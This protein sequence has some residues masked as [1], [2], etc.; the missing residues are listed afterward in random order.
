MCT[1]PGRYWNKSQK[2]QINTL[3]SN[4]NFESL[5]ASMIYQLFRT[6]SLVPNPTQGWGKKPTKN[7]KCIADDIERIHHLR[8]ECAHR[9]DT[10]IDQA[11]FDKFFVQFREITLR[12]ASDY[13]HE[14]TAIFRDSLDPNRQK[15]LEEV[16]QKLEDIKGIFIIHLCL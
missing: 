9:C 1:Q 8:N 11:T 4:L 12:I 5:D 2:L 10:C 6:F 16:H 15:D 14:L 13:E 7:D 3:Q